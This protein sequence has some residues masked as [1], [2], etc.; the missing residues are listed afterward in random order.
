MSWLKNIWKYKEMVIIII[1]FENK[2]RTLGMGMLKFI[3]F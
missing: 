1:I 2:T 3:I